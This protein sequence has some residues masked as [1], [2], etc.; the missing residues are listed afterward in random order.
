MRKKGR[1][2]ACLACMLIN[3]LPAAA[4]VSAGD[5]QVMARALGFMSHPPTGVVEVGII[6]S[7]DV[8]QSSREARSAEELL[9]G[10][11]VGG[12]T[13]RPQLIP[14]TQVA[15]AHV[16]LLFLTGGLGERAQPVAAASRNL[17]IPC[18]TTDLAQVTRGVCAIGIRSQPRVEVLVN[19]AAAAAAGTSF[20]TVFSLMIT[21]L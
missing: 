2:A 21:E 7:P 9:G 5:M 15:S 12:V 11:S 17:R 14:L 3:A 19:R 16:G 18:I 8:P 4:D 6:Y 20:S 1:I 13:L 10:L